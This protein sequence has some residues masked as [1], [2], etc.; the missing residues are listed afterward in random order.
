MSIAVCGLAK[1][2]EEVWRP[3]DSF[4]LVLPRNSESL[5]LLQRLRDEAHR[6]AITYQR[7]TR[8][9]SLK[10]QLLD[11][12][13]VGESMTKKLLTTFGSVAGVKEASV[14][15]LTRVSGVGPQLASRIH[16]ALHDSS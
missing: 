14:E 6:V 1:R 8:K 15:D 13:G 5:F 10:S 3:G 16:S 11:I 12:P 9:R 7:T 4:P 2:L